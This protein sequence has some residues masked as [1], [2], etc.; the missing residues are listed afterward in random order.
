M[1]KKAEM[2]DEEAIS[3]V[4]DEIADFVIGD[5]CAT[6]KCPY[7]TSCLKSY[8]ECKFDLALD[9]F[10]KLIR[11]KNQRITDLNKII[12]DTK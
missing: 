11:R 9:H 4:R 3:I 7:R 10:V 8:C 12:G 1:S 6:Q 2:T 5:Y